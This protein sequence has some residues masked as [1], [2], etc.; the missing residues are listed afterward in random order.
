MSAAKTILPGLLVCMVVVQGAVADVVRQRWGPAKMQ[1]TWPGAMRTSKTGKTPTLVFDLSALPKGTAV[2][3][4]TLCNER[5]GQPRD[6]IAIYA[7]KKLGAN[8]EPVCGPKRLALEPP[9][10]RTF[11]ATEAVKAWVANPAGN[12]GLSLAQAEG[13][14]AR[15]A[16]LDI[17]YEGK[18]KNVPPQ[19]SKLRAVHHDGQT[20]LTWKE[21]A[22]FQ[23]RADK[24]FWVGQF[25]RGK[26]PEIFS[27]PGK[28]FMGLP[29]INC[30]RQAEL[31][32]LQMYDVIPPRAGTQDNPKYVRR[33]GWPEVTYRIYRSTKPITARNLKD[34]ELVGEAGA[35][36]GYDL[37]MIGIGCH[38]EYYD[39]HE[40]PETAIPTYCIEDGKCIP[41]GH[42]FYV[43]TPQANGAFF[44]CVT[45]V[46][47]GTENMTAVTKANS[48]SAAV[49]EKKGPFKP[50]LQ[51]VTEERKIRRYKYY[52]WP[53]PPAANL[54]LQRA[55][56]VRLSVPKELKEP[57]GLVMRR[58]D[59]GNEWIVLDAGG[60]NWYAGELAYN[61]GQGTFRAVSE[62]KVDYFDERYMLY[63][64]QGIL[65]KWKVDPN[66]IEIGGANA[67]TIR[68]PEIFKIMYAGTTNS[69]EIN[70]DP[71]WNPAH[72]AI[73][74]AFGPA[75]A[76][77]TVDGHKA[78][79]IVSVHWYLRTYPDRDIPFF[80]A[81][82]GGKESGHAIEFGWQDDPRGW[83]ALR[84]GRVPF[85]GAWGGGRISR[86]VY[87]V[88]GAMPRDKTLPAFSRCSLDSNPGNGDPSDG[89]PWGQM[90]GFCIWDF[91]SSVD[92]AGQWEMTVGLASDAD[93]DRCTVDI[94]PRRC[95]AFK[96]KPGEE[97]TWTNTALK[98]NKEIQTSSVKADKW[99]LVTIPKAVV[100][101][102]KNR[103]RITKKD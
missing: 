43:Y 41:L 84:H 96:P 20:F 2:F 18:P 53:A 88:I 52:C 12:L 44:Y 63:T 5:V 69:F 93:R 14:D 82:H 59:R 11:D 22:V 81:T 97:F 103:I 19:V 99:G 57:C 42:A 85:V 6:P 56:R 91:D 33:K 3:K 90:N 80:V 100:S 37:S 13:F 16:Y 28:G 92:K 49:K 34:A 8:G 1:C 23:P 72:G 87:K 65:S 36:S 47:N 31:R 40:L 10:Y 75:D 7:I 55:F 86:E 89:D 95:V 24:S 4:A 70:F 67:F 98:G 48:L 58:R 25:Q 32:R 45:V 15:R 83:S 50:V 54:P 26:P 78:W 62:C 30:I 64:I 73:A 79:D 66:R 60:K 68:H 101:K 102:G 77:M 51:Y 9:R 39:K 71:K 61:A 76:A 29:R 27:E 94:T 21:M 74:G 46:K 38:G 35:L 17:C